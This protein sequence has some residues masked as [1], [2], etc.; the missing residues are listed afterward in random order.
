M[1]NQPFDTK[2]KP[3]SIH[4]SSK[5]LVWGAILAADLLGKGSPIS[6]V[7]GCREIKPPYLLLC[8]HASVIDFP[9]AAKACL[10]YYPNWV[11]SIEEFIGREAMLRNVGGIYKRKFTPEVTTVRQMLGV[12]TKDKNICVMYPEAR[13]SIAGIN[14]RMSEGIG[15]LVKLARIPVLTLMEHGSYFWQPQWNKSIFPYHPITAEMREI[16]TAEEAQSLSED[17]IQKRIEA[18]IVYD[19]YQWHYDHK[20]RIRSAKRAELL[21]RVLY[22][23]PVCGRE[24]S[25]NS[26]GSGLNCESCHA[27]WTMDEYGKLH[28]SDGPDVFTHVPDWYRWERANVSKEV[29]DGTYR[30]EDTVILDRMVNAEVGFEYLGNVTM[31]QDESGITLE[32]KL[33]NGENFHLHRGA[34]SM[35][36]IHIE[37]DFN[38]KGTTRRGPYM[39]IADGGET[40]FVSPLNKGN[41]LTRIHFATEALYDK[42]RA[43]EKEI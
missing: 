12:L 9:I 26:K 20:I 2:R 28:R 43:A 15:K 33:D 31:I 34:R 17:E 4:S 27:S 7:G 5:L 35:E 36:S 23:C 21:H 22:Q 3:E 6:Y 41:C 1:N 37:Y 40:Y 32:G 11:I 19:D 8:N 29:Q 24:F 30:F 10:P 13:Y 38:K 16:I 39:D 25:M 18:A 42:A 14:E